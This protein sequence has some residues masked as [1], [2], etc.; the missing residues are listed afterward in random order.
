[1]EEWQK[2]KIISCISNIEDKLN[3]IKNEINLDKPYK[4]YILEKI[5]PILFDAKCIK[6]MCEDEENE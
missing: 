1:M 6:N 4:Y 2:N 3:A 5:E